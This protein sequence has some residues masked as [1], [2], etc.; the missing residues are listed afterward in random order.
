[1]VAM[2]D[3]CLLAH[4]GVGRCLVLAGSRRWYAEVRDSLRDR[5]RRH[6]RDGDHVSRM[7]NPN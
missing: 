5:L 1:L 7:E 2:A 4:R 6:P 3:H